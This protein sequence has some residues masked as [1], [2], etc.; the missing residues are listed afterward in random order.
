MR[1]NG[2][3]ERF[4]KR[5]DGGREVARQGGHLLHEA[6]RLAQHGGQ[7]VQDRLESMAER[8][9]GLLNAL[10]MAFGGALITALSRSR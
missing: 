8:Q 7:R 10:A 1:R 9:P 4:P 6:Q 3:L 2:D 5:R